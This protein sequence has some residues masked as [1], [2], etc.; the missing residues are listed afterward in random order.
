MPRDKWRSLIIVWNR[1]IWMIKELLQPGTK[2]KEKKCILT[3]S[4]YWSAR[5]VLLQWSQDPELNPWPPFARKL[6]C[7]WMIWPPARSHSHI[8]TH[9]HLHTIGCGHDSWEAESE[10]HCRWLFLLVCPQINSQCEAP[11][12]WWCFAALT[13]LLWRHLTEKSILNY[14][15]TMMQKQMSSNEPCQNSVARF[16]S[17]CCSCTITVFTQWKDALPPPC[18]RH[19][20]CVGSL[21]P[22]S[23]TTQVTKIFAVVFPFLR[24][25]VS[26]CHGAY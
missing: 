13:T 24:A 17:S 12:H 6:T 2:N 18:A 5:A 15:S 22:S 10:F 14:K 23:T 25:C 19:V 3:A 26:V 7:L 8:H 21:N 11:T 16:M 1:V 9:I 20:Q 4:V